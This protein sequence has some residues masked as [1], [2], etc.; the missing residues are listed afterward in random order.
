M[1][2]ADT[3]AAIRAIGKFMHIVIEL[4]NCGDVCSECYHLS[5]DCSSEHAFCRH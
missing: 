3:C 4:S 1:N 2:C 5:F